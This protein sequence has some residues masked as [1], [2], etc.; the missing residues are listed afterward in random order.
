MSYEWAKR[1]VEIVCKRENPDWDGESFDYGCSCYQSALKA[2]K[3]LCEDG[4]S[5][6][7]FGAT[8]NILEKLMDGRPLTPITEDDFKDVQFSD[9]ECVSKQCPRMTSLFQYTNE[10]G[11]FRYTDVDR[12]YNVNIEEPSDTYW[13]GSFGIL[14]E[15]FP[16]K[17]PYWGTKE[18]YKIYEKTFLVDEKNGDFDTKW[19][20]YVIT[21]EGEKVIIDRYFHE[22]DE[23]HK[24][25][26]ISR[27]EYFKLLDMRLDPLNKKVA[28]HLVWTLISNSS[29]DSEIMRR[30]AMY[31]EMPE[32]W[33]K[34]VMDK[35]DE[36]CVF[37]EGHY[38]LNTFNVTQALCQFEGDTYDEVTSKY[39]ELKEISDFLKH[40]LDCIEAN[41]KCA[42]AKDYENN[43]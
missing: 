33:K 1:E 25:E 20:A 19:I 40:I 7:S 32:E 34:L 6:Y 12:S 23:T 28:T 35:L 30:E 14:D 17:L 36:M 29:S 41:A 39:P 3:S 38:D 4:H 31:K 26:E 43:I 18:K 10:D 22:N 27:E 37:F 2:Y 11:T 5:G 24:M 21:P 13:S 16:I 9:M 8:R 15:M 42:V